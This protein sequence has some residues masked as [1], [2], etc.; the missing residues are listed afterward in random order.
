MP[1]VDIRIVQ[2]ETIP[3]GTMKEILVQANLGHEGI[4][5][6]TLAPGGDLNCTHPKGISLMTEKPPS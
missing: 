6:I 4:K 1:E 3:L 5:L 2:E